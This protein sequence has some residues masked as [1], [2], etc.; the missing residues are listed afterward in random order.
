MQNFLLFFLSGCCYYYYRNNIP[1]TR[2][3]AYFCMVMLA[4]AIIGT[5]F[6]EIFIAIFGAYLLF[7][8][9]FSKK[10]KL[11]DTAKFGDLSYGIYL[12]GWPVQ[13]LVMVYLGH[14]LNFWGTLSVSLLFL[15]PIAFAS[16]HLI[17]KPALALKNKSL[18]F[19][20]YDRLSQSFKKL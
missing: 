18:D 19:G 2:S 5:K 20:I 8:F 14:K 9:V 10:V 6:F 12:F 15:V 1:K 3:I 4:L 11:P 16:W 17:E 7:Y 13:Q